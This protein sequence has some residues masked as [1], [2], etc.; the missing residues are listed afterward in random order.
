MGM[1]YVK[2][3]NAISG[4]YYHNLHVVAY[5][6]RLFAPSATISSRLRATKN[7]RGRRGYLHLHL[8][9]VG[10]CK[11]SAEARRPGERERGASREAIREKITREKIRAR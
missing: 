8:C 4:C 6:T 9:A 11:R 10:Q 7:L 5:I 3:A 2:V 1:A